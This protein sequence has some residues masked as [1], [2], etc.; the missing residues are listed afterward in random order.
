MFYVY[1]LKE[2]T[3]LEEQRNSTGI[4]WRLECAKDKGAAEITGPKEAWLQVTFKKCTATHEPGGTPVTC[5]GK[6]ETGK[7]N[8]ALETFHQIAYPPYEGLTELQTEGQYPTP[9][10]N[11]TCG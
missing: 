9:L 4:A 8:T 2:P 5:K 7:V 10:A 11:I 6:L 1:G 3:Q